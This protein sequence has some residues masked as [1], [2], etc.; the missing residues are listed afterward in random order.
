VHISRAIPLT[1]THP[2]LSPT[3]E[4]GLALAQAHATAQQCSVVG[5]YVAHAN[6][7]SSHVDPRTARLARSACGEG[8]EALVLVVS[9]R[10]CDAGRERERE[11]ERLGE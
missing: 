11:R 1:H 10:C 7:A 2:A 6:V 5:V 3:A 8:S 4:A 9:D